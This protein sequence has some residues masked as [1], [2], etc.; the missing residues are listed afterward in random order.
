MM[1]QDLT[2]L[3]KIWMVLSAHVLTHKSQFIPRPSQPDDKHPEA[4]REHTGV[5]IS[6]YWVLVIRVER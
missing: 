3:N 4:Y 2:F 5:E 6:S 1:V